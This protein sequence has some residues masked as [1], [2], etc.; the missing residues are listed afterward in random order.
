MSARVLVVDNDAEQVELLRDVLERE[1]YE[2]SGATDAAA[3]LAVIEGAEPAVVLTDL[4]MEGMDGLALLREVRERAPAA[5]VILMT[6]FG[7]LETAIAAMRQGAFDYLTK[8]FKL[9]EVTLA[10]H[11]ALDDRA[12][13]EENQRLRL[14]V[15]RRYGWDS[16]IGRSPAMEAALELLRVVAPSDASVLLLGESGTGKELA[17]R[18]LHHAGPRSRGPF[19]AVNCAAI[20]EALLEAELFGHE[21]GAFTGADRRRAGLLQEAH[22]GTLFL[23]EV[24]DMPL[25]LQAKVLRA[26]QE[27]AVRPVGSRETVQLDFRL[28]VAT[29]TDL[30]A[31]VREGRFREDLYYRLAVIP[32]RLPTLR[33]RPEDIPL[34]ARHFLER[35]AAEAGKSITGLGDGVMEWL[36]AHPWPGNVRELENTIARAVALASGQT[37]TLREVR[38]LPGTASRASAL[39]PTLEGLQAR[40]VEEVL[41]ET[42]GDRPAAARILGVSLRTLQRWT[43]TGGLAGTTVP[44]PAPPEPPPAS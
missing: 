9:E 11:R 41:A 12:V 27:K 44:D 29:N 35:C 2:V 6:A 37:L 4:R 20:P 19:V 8:P 33:E 24:A 40:Y 28:I 39:R 34:L 31:R 25:A 14:E 10:V 38:P 22:G 1:G 17:A 42:R 23:D 30:A 18:A 13:R 43:R 7:S 3:A 16:L 32:V 36:L 5:R 21:K 26:L 15:E